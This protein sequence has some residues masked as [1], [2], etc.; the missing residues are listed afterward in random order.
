MSLGEAAAQGLSR[1]VGKVVDSFGKDSAHAH[2]K[3]GLYV[4][5]ERP[6][7]RVVSHKSESHPA[8]RK[9][10]SCIADGRIHKVERG[11]VLRRTV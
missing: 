8:V 6:R 9:H 1:E 10:C 11:I 3:V 5:M 4:A 2:V 7:P